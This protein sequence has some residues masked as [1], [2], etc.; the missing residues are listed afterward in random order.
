MISLR[1]SGQ[2]SAPDSCLYLLPDESK[3]NHLNA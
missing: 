2:F 3:F 1:S